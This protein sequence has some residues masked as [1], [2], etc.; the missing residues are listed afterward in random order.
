MLL[1]FTILF[2]KITF[3]VLVKNRFGAISVPFFVLILFFFYSQCLFIDFLFF[4]VEE[5]SLGN[6][7]TL[8]VYSQEYLY[9][10]LLYLSFFIGFSFVILLG[11]RTIK[12]TDELHVYNERKLYNFLLIAIIT[13]LIIYITRNL[14]GAD[15]YD[16]INFQT[17]NK[18]ISIPIN[19]AT[20]G[21]LIL[22]FKNIVNYNKSKLF[23][24]T[25]IVIIGHG[26]IEGGREI[27][28]YILL[29]YIFSKKKTGISY[30]MFF[31]GLAAFVFLLFWKAI[32]VFLFKL[33]DI[34][35]FLSF[36]QN[37]FIFSFSKLDPMASLLMIKDYLNGDPFFDQYQFSYILN[38]GKQ[39]LRTFGLIDYDSISEST[40]NYYIPEKAEMGGGLAFSGILESLLNF[41]YF[42]PFI[43]GLV[44]GKISL[45]INSL[46]AKS[47]FLYAVASV[48][49][50]I[51]SLKLVR[52]ELAVIL[53]IYFLPMF[54]AYHIFYK[55][56]FSKRKILQKIKD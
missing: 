14:L 47:F 46:K 21:W 32:S 55:F 9:I 54:I 36:V 23:I 33:N 28:I 4:R 29:A 42:G 6:L 2:I 50:I 19:I 20:F 49:F 3:I 8:N 17:S 12:I 22:Y 35:G 37:D 38:T 52:T 40:A 10:T 30:K 56:S 43:L 45:L 44:L 11:R 1:L 26:I 18:L 41:W 24:I 27:F 16:K 39:F 34:G 15:R 31:L 7:G 53:K 5:I 51:I 48:F 25:S 13:I